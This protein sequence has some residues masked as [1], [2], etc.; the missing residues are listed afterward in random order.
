M[1]HSEKRISERQL[2]C[3]DMLCVDIL[4]IVHLFTNI[5]WA[6]SVFYSNC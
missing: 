6:R 3:T 5:K 2:L 1:Q 4:T